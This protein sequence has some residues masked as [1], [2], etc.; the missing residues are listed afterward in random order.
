[1]RC[2]GGN[3]RRGVIAKLE[4]IRPR[5]VHKPEA[6]VHSVCVCLLFAYYASVIGHRSCECG[7]DVVTEV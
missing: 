7:S 1:M 2:E 6:E 5:L 3:R 4:L